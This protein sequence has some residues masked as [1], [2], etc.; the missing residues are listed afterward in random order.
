MSEA[1]KNVVYDNF[2][3]PN[4]LKQMAI[5]P[6]LIDLSFYFNWIMAGTISE[7]MTRKLWFV[8][9]V[10]NVYIYN[11]LLQPPSLQIGRV[12]QRITRLPTEQKIAGS[13]PAVV[14]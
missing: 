9:L 5:A 11:Q 2:S 3:T 12:A 8:S 4:R 10:A 7:L 13:S 14:A 1:S 6:F